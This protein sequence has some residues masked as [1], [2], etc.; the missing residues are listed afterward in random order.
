MLHKNP[1]R[2]KGNLLI[3]KLLNSNSAFSFFHYIFLG[4]LLKAEDQVS[5]LQHEQVHVE[6]KHTLD[7]LFFEL[8]RIVFW[9]NPFVYIYQSRI[10]ELHEYIADA[11]SVEHQNKAEYYQNLLS[12]VFDT[13]HISFVTP[14]FKQSLIKKRIIMISK[15]KSKQINLFKYA[16]LIPMIFAI[17]VYI[18]C[19]DEKN[20]QEGLDLSQFTYSLRKGSDMTETQKA[21]HEKYEAFLKSNLDYVGWAEVNPERDEVTYSV[22]SIGEKIPDNFSKSSVGSKDG[23]SYV[24]YHNFW[25]QNKEHYP[26]SDGNVPFALI[27]EVPIYPGCESL[28]TN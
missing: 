21:V 18:S 16:L 12:Q 10:V 26:D 14:F 27:D 9:F 23:S 6:Q 8:L 19:T 13:Q 24:F 20:Q 25:D 4:E 7:L 17:L 2:W 22:H 11:K 5:I 1:K 28:A 3:V 15:S